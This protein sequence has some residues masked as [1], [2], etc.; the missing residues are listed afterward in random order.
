M[1]TVHK[2]VT[3]LHLSHGLSWN[4]IAQP[5]S[6]YKGMHTDH[7]PH[8]QTDQLW[9]PP[10]TANSIHCT[11]LLLLPTPASAALLSRLSDASLPWAAL[12]CTWV[13]CSRCGRCGQYWCS[14]CTQCW[15]RSSCRGARPWHWGF[16]GQTK[17]PMSQRPSATQC[18]ILPYTISAYML[19][20]ETLSVRKYW[21]SQ[22]LDEPSS[23]KHPL[24]LPF[25]RV[26]SK[27]MMFGSEC[28]HSSV[29]EQSFLH[30]TVDIA[31]TARFC[32]NAQAQL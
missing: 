18:G 4:I 20:G 15:R 26:S 2:L 32:I 8:D 16:R 29:K 5:I 14:Q 24:P 12:A 31:H 6:H 10:D 19:Q 7:F 23:A 28:L 21:R 27:G 22:L 17:G 11:K 9:P 25:C 13:L 1:A 30:R 3:G